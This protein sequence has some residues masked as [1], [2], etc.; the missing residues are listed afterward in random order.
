MGTL[1]VHLQVVGFLLMLLGLSHAF[2]NRFFEWDVELAGVSLFT[3]RVF[4]VHTFFVAMTVTMMGAFSL[5]FARALVE[6]QPLSRAILA[7]MVLFWGSRLVAQFTAYESA[8]WRGD[9]FR[10]RM[11]VAFSMFWV[12]VTGTYGMALVWSLRQIG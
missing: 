7:G 12:Y 4:F 2:F 9:R 8:I 6:P 1:T 3:R 5:M 11:H 10:T